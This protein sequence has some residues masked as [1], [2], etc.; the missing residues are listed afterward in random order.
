M[1]KIKLE[2][3]GERKN[4]IMRHTERVLKYGESEKKIQKKWSESQ[5]L[6]CEAYLF[7]HQ[8]IYGVCVFFF[9]GR[10]VHYCINTK[11]TNP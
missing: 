3:A 8:K 9:M 7:R 5:P 1:K 6:L 4:L 11:T 10:R 2:S